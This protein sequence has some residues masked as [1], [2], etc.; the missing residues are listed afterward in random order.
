MPDAGKRSAQG[1]A[2]DANTQRSF[3][4]VQ[5]RLRLQEEKMLRIGYRTVYVGPHAIKKD[6]GVK[7]TGMH[8]DTLWEK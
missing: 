5:V 3:R 8:L 2:I 6:G 1:V 7:P 4:T